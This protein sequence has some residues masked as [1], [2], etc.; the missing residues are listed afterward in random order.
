MRQS[1]AFLDGEGD[2]YHERNKHKEL[3]PRV[4]AAIFDLGIKPDHVVEVGCG[5]GG[6]LN[7]IY[8]RYECPCIGIDP[9]SEAISEGKKKFPSLMFIHGDARYLYTWED[10]VLDLIV[11][12]FCLYL[13]DRDDLF[14]IVS[15]ADR[16]LKM[17]GHL[18]IHDFDSWEPK[19][20]PY[21]H[22]QG[23]YSYKMSYSDLW[24]ANPAYDFVSRTIT[25]PET[26]ITIL[27]KEGWER[28]K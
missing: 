9:S 15:A 8:S 5:N 2:K 24:R 22:K 28:F 21:K 6:Y 13:V 20:V 17:G 16:A 12:G 14:A 11:F 27:R 10:P 4:L 26:A 18:V 3:N 7:E 23:I 19:T 25:G 1:K